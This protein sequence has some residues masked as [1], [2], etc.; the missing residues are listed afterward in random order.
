MRAFVTIELPEDVFEA[1]RVISAIRDPWQQLLAQLEAAGVKHTAS[2]GP[3]RG[4]RSAETKPP[5]RRRRSNATAAL[6]EAVAGTA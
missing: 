2:L 3:A 5:A 1:A 6:S 4:P